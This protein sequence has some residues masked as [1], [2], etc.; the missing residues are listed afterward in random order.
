MS[1]LS[2]CSS[3]VKSDEWKFRSDIGCNQMLPPH[4]RFIAR[5]LFRLCEVLS[6]LCV[7]ALL[8]QT[9]G[10]PPTFIII[11]VELLFYFVMY[12][13]KYLGDDIGNVVEIL[14][15]HPNLSLRVNPDEH[16]DPLFGCVVRTMLCWTPIACLYLSYNRVKSI[17]CPSEQEKEQQ[18]SD[19]REESSRFRR[20]RQS[21][22]GKDEKDNN[23]QGCMGSCVNRNLVTVHFSHRFI[24]QFAELL[25]VYWLFNQ[26]LAGFRTFLV[27]VLFC[28]LF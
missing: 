17:F 27:F 13:D 9:I 10:L 20:L 24:E 19:N 5:A 23:I 12:K 26:E 4:P 3:V 28:F 6:R 8:T 7:V 1:V 15:L 14:I 18:K 21:F 22:A 25:I 2:I 11:G 16:V